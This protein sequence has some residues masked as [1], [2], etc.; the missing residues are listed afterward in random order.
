MAA[1]TKIELDDE[2]DPLFV[3]VRMSVREAAYLAMIT[4]AQSGTTAKQLVPGWGESANLGL[5]ES[6]VGEF[7]N[8]YWSGGTNHALRELGQF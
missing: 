8:R 2:G 7:I 6:V 4:G 3:T 1:V 5:Y